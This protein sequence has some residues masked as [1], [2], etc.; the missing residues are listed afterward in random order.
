MRKFLETDLT[1]LTH[2]LV[3]GS[4][5]CGSVRETKIYKST[6]HIGKKAGEHKLKKYFQNVA[7]IKVFNFVC[8]KFKT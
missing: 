3:Q 5:N 8:R 6:I 7:L 2:V 1:G 4:A